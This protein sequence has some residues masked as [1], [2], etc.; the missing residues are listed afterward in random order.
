MFGPRVGWDGGHFQ[1]CGEKCLRLRGS[2]EK[3][4]A[5]KNGVRLGSDEVCDVEFSS[6]F[7]VFG[8]QHSQIGYWF[9]HP[10]DDFKCHMNSG[11]SK[12]FSPWN[13]LR[14]WVFPMSSKQVILLPHPKT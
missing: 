6:I 5:Q 12:R 3:D 2:I 4:G 14:F 8:D 9:I 11:G 13:G 10:R 1:G 7:V